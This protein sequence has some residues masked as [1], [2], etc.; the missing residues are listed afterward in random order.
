IVSIVDKF[1]NKATGP[2]K[3]RTKLREPVDPTAGVGFL[4]VSTDVSAFQGKTY[5]QV[6]HAP[7]ATCP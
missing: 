2:S 5:K 3:T 7:P 1:Q 6:F 4:E